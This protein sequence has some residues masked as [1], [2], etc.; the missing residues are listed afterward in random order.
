[1]AAG[2]TTRMRKWVS[3]EPYKCIQVSTMLWLYPPLCTPRRRAGMMLDAQTAQPSGA[4]W[5]MHQRGSP[6]CK[7]PD[8]KPQHHE[9]VHHPIA[10][11]Y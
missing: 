6:T 9:V 1:M 3:R 8:K 11:L 5:L 2:E 4:P 10:R 7:R